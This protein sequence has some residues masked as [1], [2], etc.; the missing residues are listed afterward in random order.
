VGDVLIHAGDIVG[1]YGKGY[2]IV[3]DLRSFVAWLQR[4]APSYEH[5]VFI[6]GNHDT[7]LDCACRIDSTRQ[8]V[9][10]SFPIC[11]PMSPT[12]KMTAAT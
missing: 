9:V 1:N 5:V 3:S 8:C 6:A 10:C 4:V 11:R 2:D 7:L 12:L